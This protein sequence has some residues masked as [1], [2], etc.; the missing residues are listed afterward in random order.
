ML[1]MIAHA[2]NPCFSVRALHFGQEIDANVKSS[3]KKS[4][5]PDDYQ[6]HQYTNGSA[7][8]KLIDCRASPL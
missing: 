5:D 8:R 7:S 2:G 4:R 3:Q 1:T 6:T